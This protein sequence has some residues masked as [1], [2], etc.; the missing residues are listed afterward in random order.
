[1]AT[2]TTHSELRPDTGQSVGGVELL[3][4]RRRGTRCGRPT[5]P[6]YSRPGVTARG[7]TPCAESYVLRVP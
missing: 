2:L 3:A 6:R 1:M 5:L 4:S 7:S